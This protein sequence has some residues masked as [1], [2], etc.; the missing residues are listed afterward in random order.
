MFETC[1]AFD[2]DWKLS[3]SNSSVS[4]SRKRKLG[5]LRRTLEIVPL[6]GGEATLCKLDSLA[7]S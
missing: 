2:R 6:G 7:A 4:S 3:Y 5:F 1:K